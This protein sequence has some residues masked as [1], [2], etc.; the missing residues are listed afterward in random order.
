MTEKSE[1][2]IILERDLFAYQPDRRFENTL[3]AVTGAA[4]SIGSHL[5][6]T[7]IE[8]TEAQLLLIDQN[9]YA[10]NR[11]LDQNRPHESRIHA[12]LADIHNTS[13]LK[14]CLQEHRPAIMV[15][16]AAY[17]QVPMLE[18]YP[19]AAVLNN[20]RNTELV[21][22]TALESGVKK[23][24]FISTDKVFSGSNVL[25]KSKKIAEY[26]V[27][28]KPE[29]LPSTI[30]RFGNVLYSRGSASEL[31]WDQILEFKRLTITDP[32]ATRYFIA[33]EEA[34]DFILFAMDRESAS[35]IY[36]LYQDRQIRIL[37]LARR[38]YRVFHEEDPEGTWW[39]KIKSRQGDELSEFNLDNII[40]GPL[41]DF[42]MIRKIKEPYRRTG[43]PS[44]HKE[45]QDLYTLAGT[46]CSSDKIRQSLNRLC[47][48]ID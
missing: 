47:S 20:M 4:G 32:E 39:E 18:R 23:F 42:P 41:N 1:Y 3:I 44:I 40:D 2:K 46:S 13:L 37:D 35:S 27:S 6:K 48:L 26:L 17:K 45:L 8:K 31:F 19:E 21:Y 36:Y 28:S 30:L 11:L 16:T 29:I 7:L 14:N 15:H 34:S 38:M 10:L 25:G 9:E 5:V 12:L 43:E 33:P 24:I 22:W